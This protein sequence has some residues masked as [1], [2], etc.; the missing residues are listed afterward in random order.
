MFERFTKEARTV[1][2]LAQEEARRLRH[3]YIGT[4]HLLLAMLSAD[5]GPGALVLRDHGLDAADVRRRVVAIVGP[6]GGEL[7]EAA[8]AT[9]GIDLEE[10]RRATEASFGPGA[11]DA[12]DRRGA[13]PKGHIPF[14]KRAK[15]V[16]E[17]SVRET[18][19][20]GG[21]HIGE[22]HLLL[23]LI[24]EGEGVAAQV[25]VQ[26]GADLTVLRDEVVRRISSEA[27]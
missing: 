21:N 14:S 23:G 17:L 19:R 3:R 12:G 25:L 26:A 1:V 6:P 10:V 4:E 7:D 15:K 13:M 5:G 24:R 2:V 9:I 18:L 22:G 8:L 27:A 20:L 16:L 11:L